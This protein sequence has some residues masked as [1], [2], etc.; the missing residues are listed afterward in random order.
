VP[1]QSHLNSNAAE[2]ATCPAKS[3]DS[4]RQIFLTLSKT[5]RFTSPPGRPVHEEAVSQPLKTH[6]CHSERSEESNNYSK[7]QNR[8]SSPAKGGVRM[9]L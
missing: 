3:G 7:L 4:Q 8:D 9:T 1:K 5:L 6:S 2:I